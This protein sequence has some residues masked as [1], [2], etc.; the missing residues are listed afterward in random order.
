MQ[1]LKSLPFLEHFKPRLNDLNANNYSFVKTFRFNRHNKPN[2]KRSAYWKFYQNKWFITGCVTV[3]G[4]STHTNDPTQNEIRKPADEIGY[5]WKANTQYRIMDYIK[6]NESSNH[7]PTLLDNCVGGIFPHNDHL[8]TQDDYYSL[9]EMA[10][11]VKHIVVFGVSHYGKQMKQKG[12]INCVVLDSFKQW[13]STYRPIKISPLRDKIIKEGDPDC[14]VVDNDTHAKEHS[15]EALLP[16]LQYFN[17]DINLVPILVNQMDF[18]SMDVVSEKLSTIITDYIKENKLTLGKDI[19][20]FISSDSSHYGSD[21]NNTP[22]GNGE[23]GHRKGREADLKI[24]NEHLQGPLQRKK[25]KNFTEEK[26]VKSGWCGRYSIPFGMLVIDKVWGK[27]GNK[28]QLNGNLICYSDTL[29]KG[30]IPVKD[31]KELGITGPFNTNHWVGHCTLSF[32]NI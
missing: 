26:V 15:I 30:V 14:M 32:N 8:F 9:L 13:Q 16:G 10:S 25:I 22:F 19:L 20:F 5:A 12:F 2:T 28:T 31:T 18:D 11:D 7:E 23:E 24:I 17:K 3:G 6:E 4:V 29:T 27:L 1:R 21:F